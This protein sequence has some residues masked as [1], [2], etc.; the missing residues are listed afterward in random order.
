MASINYLYRSKKDQ[1]SLKLRLLFRYN[2]RDY[3]LESDSKVVVTKDYWIHY[4]RKSKIKDVLVR[5]KQREIEESLNSLE[6]TIIES[7]FKSDPKYIDKSWLIATI[8]T[9]YR[10]GEDFRSEY[11]Q[12]TFQ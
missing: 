12:K 5:N 10:H 3:Q 7:F 1:A 11:L 8:E 2:G 9:H 6:K 4:H